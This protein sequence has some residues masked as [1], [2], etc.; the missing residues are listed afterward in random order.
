[1]RHA[2][3]DVTPPSIPNALVAHLPTPCLVID[4]VACERNIGRA[5][6]L[7]ADSAAKLRPHFKAHKCVELMRR[8]VEAGSC[9]GVTAATAFEAETL[10]EHGFADILVA[11]QIVH[12]AGLS[13][14]GRAARRSRIT[15]AVDDLAHVSLLGDEAKRSDVRFDVVIEIDVGM[16]RCGIEP[17]SD[18]LYSLAVAV[19]KSG[20]LEL[21]GLQGYEGHAVL[22]PGH[23]VRRDHVRRAGRILAG[24]RSRLLSRGYPCTIVSGGGTGTMDLITEVDILDEVQ[25][26]SYALMDATYGSLGL[27]FENALFVASTVISHPRSER[28][29]VNAGLKA[30]SAEY[31]LPT[32]AAN[33]LEVVDLSDEHAVVSVGAGVPIGIGAPLYLVPAHIDPTINLHDVMFA[34][35]SQRETLDVWPVEGRRVEATEGPLIP[36]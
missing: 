23:D 22:L 24:E 7:F 28:L 36:W 29:I 17:G 27:A 4:V 14:L 16:S 25:A 31:G 19:E 35:D 12:R 5:A 6:K 2:L 26:G 13:A 33:G 11:N 30:L 9:V 15:V 3:G 10:A 34:W 8:Q 32:A 1:M 20:V 21:R 18:R